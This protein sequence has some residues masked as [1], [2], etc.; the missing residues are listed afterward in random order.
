MEDPFQ[1]INRRILGLTSLIGNTPLFEIEITYRG[2]PFK[3]YAKAENLNMTGSI[4]DRIALHI[5]RQAYASK[6]IEPGYRV[7]EA[8]SGNTGIAFSAIS[9]ALGHPV[10]IFMPDWMSDERKNLIRS[11]GADIKLVSKKDGGFLE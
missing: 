2:K 6:L 8:T 5:L 9:R 3:I 4:K 10:T 11:L 7:V 1:G